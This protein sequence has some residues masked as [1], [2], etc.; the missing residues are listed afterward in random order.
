MNFI[1]KK[2]GIWGFGTVGQAALTFFAQRRARITVMDQKNPTEADKALINHHNARFIKEENIH[3]FFHGH[4]YVLASP[5]IDVRP[6]L[7]HK[8][9]LLTELD[10]FFAYWDDKTIA[11]TGSIGKTT[12]TTMISQLLTHSMPVAT[13]GNIGTCMLDLIAQQPKNY[14]I[15]ELSS[16]QLE[17]AASC[18]PD[19]AI[20]TN[21]YPNH[22]DRHE[23]KDSYALA[24]AHIFYRQH[25]NQHLILGAQTVTSAV[26]K[27][28]LYEHQGSL[29]LIAVSEYEIPDEYG[30]ETAFYFKHN[31]IVMRRNGV[32]TI[33]GTLQNL[34]PFAHTINWLYLFATWH[35]LGLPYNTIQAYA[36]TIQLP[37]HRLEWVATINGAVFYNDSKATIPEA[38]MAAVRQF[39]KP[40]ILF[41]GGL[42]KGVDRSGFVQQLAQTTISHICCFGAEAPQLDAWCKK[43]CVPS[44]CHATLEEA[45]TAAQAII[46]PGTTVLFS[47]SGSS[48]DLFENFPA[49]GKRF[50]ELVAIFGNEDNDQ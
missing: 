21:L 29:T 5:G 18:T 1:D 3:E 22:Y 16:F 37:E 39:K 46:S 8:D 42:S 20:I 14:A 19:I 34:P 28:M 44:S 30:M 41:L 6:Y 10:I 17:Y 27:K 4:H 26:I 7:K 24:K 50:K 2:V 33:G 13:G 11:V 23:S 9:K 15:L 12:L 40:I 48:Y 32:E 36:H 45:F 43:A 25:I 47:P 38:T 35:R 49:R 31:D